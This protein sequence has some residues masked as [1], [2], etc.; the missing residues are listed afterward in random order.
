MVPPI[1]PVFRA[2]G[3][4]F[5][6]PASGLPARQGVH[7]AIPL[8]EVVLNCGAGKVVREWLL[9]GTQVDGRYY[10]GVGPG[11][12]C[13]GAPG[14]NLTGCRNVTPDS[15]NR[16]QCSGY[17]VGIATSPEVITGGTYA[18]GSTTVS[19]VRCCSIQGDNSQ[20]ALP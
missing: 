6:L 5:G 14:M 10:I 11:L 18:A 8:P 15:N 9:N 19:S 4:A 17:D 2:N 3:I 20:P 16:L 12:K 7:P 1:H 13:C